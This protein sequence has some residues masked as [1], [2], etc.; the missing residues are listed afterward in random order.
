MV[1]KMAV[2][3]RF[4]I[5][6]FSFTFLQHSKSPPLGEES[7]TAVFHHADLPVAN[8]LSMSLKAFSMASV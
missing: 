7:K 8:M 4:A 6:A 1:P 3:A 2:S 5:L